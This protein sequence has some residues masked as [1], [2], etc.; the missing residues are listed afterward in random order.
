MTEPGPVRATIAWV[1][2]N[3]A[4]LTLGVPA[5]MHLN[6]SSSDRHESRVYGSRDRSHLIGASS[7]CQRTRDRP[8]PS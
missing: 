3:L 8:A 1:T 4:Q 5:P 2:T 7:A 6:A